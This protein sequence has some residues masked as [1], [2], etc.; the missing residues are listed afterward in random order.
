MLKVYKMVII[1]MAS[2]RSFTQAA[3]S[4]PNDD[5]NTALTKY[6]AG[7]GAYGGLKDTG[8]FFHDTYQTT[9]DTYVVPGDLDELYSVSNILREFYSVFY[10]IFKK[11]LHNLAVEM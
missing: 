7:E 5:N 11:M 8:S 9:D 10:S 6:A 4:R 3:L 1:M 2:S